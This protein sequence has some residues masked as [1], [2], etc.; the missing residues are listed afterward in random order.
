M[1]TCGICGIEH[2]DLP[3]CFGA[4]APWRAMVAEAEFG[5][6]VELT[7]DQCVVD[8]TSFFIRGHIEIPIHTM[9]QTLAWSVWVSLSETSFLHCSA[10]WED[11]D[12]EG[13][14]YFGWLCTPVPIYSD[15]LHLKTNVRSRAPGVVPLI[16]LQE[17][18]HPLYRDQRD[19]ISVDRLREI[20]HAILHS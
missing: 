9:A 15:T 4:D 3:L 19:G 14:G 11:P 2:D 7:K 6:R 1:W 5:S 12:R 20:A 13:D 8:R 18:D 10:R 17:C 16:E